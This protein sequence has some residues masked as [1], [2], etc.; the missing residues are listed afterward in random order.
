MGNYY[1]TEKDVITDTLV[2]EDNFEKENICEI[3]II[4]DKENICENDFVKDDEHT[5]STNLMGK[6]ILQKINE[7]KENVKKV[8]DVFLNDAK[9]VRK[10]DTNDIR[11]GKMKNCK[12]RSEKIIEKF[13]DE[14]EILITKKSLSDHDVKIILEKSILFIFGDNQ[15]CKKCNSIMVLNRIGSLPNVLFLK[16]IVFTIIYTEGHSDKLTSNF[17]R[18][19]IEQ[20]SMFNE[21]S[22]SFEKRKDIIS[23]IF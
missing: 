5:K 3:D 7:K 18:Y 1:S 10:T 22:I 11:S 15:L 12:L 8:T 9:N 19:F 21:K 2:I 20:W 23:K 6:N 16:D 13:I 14:I 17:L 4:E